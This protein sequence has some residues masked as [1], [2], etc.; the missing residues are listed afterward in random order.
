LARAVA[1]A[2]ALRAAGLRRASDMLSDQQEAPPATP[3]P[4]DM[5]TR[6][7]VRPAYNC[8]LNSVLSVLGCLCVSGRCVEDRQ[9]DYLRKPGQAPA[10][11]QPD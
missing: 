7:R 4:D 1:A 6:M 2:A 9:S 10:R 3:H 11:Q 5:L 8:V